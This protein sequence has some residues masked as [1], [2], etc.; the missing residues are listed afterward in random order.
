MKRGRVH[1]Q[2]DGGGNE[3][4]PGFNRSVHSRYL[5]G[6]IG[7]DPGATMCPGLLLLLLLLHG[8]A[9]MGR[10]CGAGWVWGDSPLTEAH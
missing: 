10:G 1:V 4:G 8:G 7:G 9:P 2:Q 6:L 3:V 5:F